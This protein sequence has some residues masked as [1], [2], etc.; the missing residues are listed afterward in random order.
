[1]ISSYT[2]K[3]EFIHHILKY[4]REDILDID[5]AVNIY[6]LQRLKDLNVESKMVA[7]VYFKNGDV[8]I[9]NLVELAYRFPE[10]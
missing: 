6:T 4:G 2:T 9:C 7:T 3:S 1:M 8:R 10:I 5:V